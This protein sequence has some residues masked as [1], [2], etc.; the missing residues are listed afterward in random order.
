MPEHRRIHLLTFHGTIVCLGA[1]GTLEH[2][3]L[4]AS[5]LPPLALDAAAL[6]R[7]G[8]TQTHSVLGEIV[9][10]ISPSGR[11]IC[12]RQDNRYLCADPGLVTMA[13]DREAASI[14]EGFLPIAEADIADL[15][16]LLGHAWLNRRTRQ[17]LRR[18]SIRV[19]E[20]FRL[21]MGS[22]IL[23][24]A[25][26][27]PLARPPG[28]HATAPLTCVLVPQEGSALEFVI[29]EPRSSL[30]LDTAIWPVRARR[31]A[32]ILTLAAHRQIA[33]REPEQEQFEADVAALQ[34][35]GGPPGLSDLLERLAGTD[36]TPATGAHAGPHIALPAS[37]CPVVSLGTQ[38]V[39]AATLQRLGLNEFPM[40]FD[41]LNATPAVVRHC[42]ETDFVELLNR[43][44]IVSLQGQQAFGQPEHGGDNLFYR[45]EF[46]LARIFNHADPTEKAA[47]RYLQTTVERFRDLLAAS[48]PKIFV[49]ITA[50][51]RDA[52]DDFEKTAS[53]LDAATEDAMLLHI[54]VFPHDRRN[55]MP[56][57]SLARRRGSHLLYY[58]HPTSHQGGPAFDRQVDNDFLAWLISTHASRPPAARATLIAHR[59]DVRQAMELFGEDPE[60]SPPILGRQAA[61]KL[62]DRANTRLRMFQGKLGLARR[63]EF[64]LIDPAR[65][66][67]GASGEAMVI[68]ITNNRAKFRFDPSVGGSPWQLLRRSLAV[69]YLLDL[70]FTENTVG[71]ARFLLEPCE[72]AYH[73]HSVAYCSSR[74]DTCLLPDIFFFESAGYDEEREAARTSTLAWSN[75]TPIL[76]W[77][78][79]TTG[80]RR[81]DPPAEGEPDDLSWLPRLD[82]CRHARASSMARH[83]DFGINTIVQMPEPHLIARIE[84]SGLMADHVQRSAFRAYKYLLVIDGNS[85][86]WSALFNN[87]LTGACVL[88]VNSPRNFRQWYSQDLKPWIHYIPI[89]A[90]L[91][92]LDDIIAWLLTHDEDAQAIGAA[93]KAFALATTFESAIAE[94]AK[95]LYEMIEAGAPSP[96]PS[97]SPH[98]QAPTP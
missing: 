11:G 86:A 83:Y 49:Q 29:A 17:T 48:G 81:F 22:T 2:H 89:E 79:V 3:A 58:M 70:I 44:N 88:K 97:A 92:D 77:R 42:I 59:L 71:Q 20:D 55:P 41:W 52:A 85:N 57:L 47:Y 76:F 82:L 62:L 60:G 12:L 4:A 9:T 98:A 80:E 93:G 6:A 16:R 27:L 61:E 32:E 68:E 51:S 72:C 26:D 74:P 8:A 14:W 87:L 19:L 96:A 34:R 28:S 69:V 67:L 84:A 37:A 31:V 33:G 78:G 5:G 66:P 24:L 91:S 54:V 95:R 40:P 21:Q 23:D 75:R 53:V 46:N 18:R 35:Q 90:D 1:H 7:G 50:A 25:R 56:L 13:W 15:R 63:T 94:G 36:P 64:A 10:E 43:E 45:R 65:N 39:I 73:E 38:C 30:L